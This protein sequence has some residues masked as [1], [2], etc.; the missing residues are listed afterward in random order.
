MYHIGTVIFG[1]PYKWVDMYRIHLFILYITE[2]WAMWLP[3]WLFWFVISLGT[4]TFPLK[5]ELQVKF[6]YFFPFL[7][8]LKTS[9]QFPSFFIPQQLLCHGWSTGQDELKMSGWWL[10]PRIWKPTIFWSAANVIHIEKQGIKNKS[11][12]NSTVVLISR[13]GR[14]Q[15][16]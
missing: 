11:C 8:D 9:R 6:V 15:R 7:Q 13:V 10:Q 12:N 4:S 1:I 2:I 14:N 16:I 3:Y 5:S